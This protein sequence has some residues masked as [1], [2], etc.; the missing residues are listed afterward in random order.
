METVVI[1]GK[2]YPA[3]FELFLQKYPNESWQNEWKIVPAYFLQLTHTCMG[4]F[5]ACFEKEKRVVI[6]TKKELIEK[7]WKTLSP[8]K[9]KLDKVL[10]YV[11]NT[12]PVCY[13][14]D[15]FGGEKYSKPEQ[16]LT[17]EEFEKLLPG[18]LRWAHGLVGG[19]MS[20]EEFAQTI[21]HAAIEA[22]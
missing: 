5:P 9:S 10:F 20:A 15:H 4:F 7:V 18:D 17:E 21:V 16:L 3:N 1:F 12:E 6:C 2:D 19:D 11:H 8:R 22:K 13:Q 14:A